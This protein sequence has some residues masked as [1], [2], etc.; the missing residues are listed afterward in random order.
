MV[1]RGL[2]GVGAAALIGLAA[3]V[4][5]QEFYVGITP[6]G[7]AMLHN[8]KLPSSFL[9]LGRSTDKEILDGEFETGKGLGSAIGFWL[10]NRYAIEFAVSYTSNTL[11]S[12]NQPNIEADLFNAAGN[13]AYYVPIFGQGREIFVG[14]GAGVKLYDWLSD[15]SKGETDFSW[16]VGGGVSIAIMRRLGLRVEAR[17]YMS[18]FGSRQAT[19]ESALQHDIQVSAGLTLSVRNAPGRQ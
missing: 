7:A 11:T 17:D 3:P 1:F 4:A 10:K 8:S 5:A 16:N 18:K 15:S 13:L 2:L 12:S 14:A 19:V 6:F 9:I